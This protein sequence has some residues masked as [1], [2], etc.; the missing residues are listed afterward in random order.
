MDFG[1]G[2]FIAIAVII[3]IIGAVLGHRAEKKRIADLMHWAI[4]NGFSFD[5][6]KRHDT[7]YHASIFDRGHS[8]WSSCHAANTIPDATPGLDA[9]AS[10]ELFQ[11]H[12]AITTHNGKSSTT[13]HYHFT[14]CAADLGIDFGQLEFREEHLGDKIASTFGYDDIDFEDAEFSRRFMV[15]S[16]DRS[17]AYA[18]IGPAIM[19]T[20]LRFDDFHIETSGRL[21]FV[22]LK[23]K[24][25][26]RRYEYLRSLVL[27]I[28]AQIPRVVVNEERDLRNLPPVLEAG[29][30]A[31]QSR[32]MIDQLDAPHGV[33]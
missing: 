6:T 12:Y 19:R 16:P 18:L 17:R 14:C 11:Y 20:L 32:R 8:R 31:P 4:Q 3:V 30:A 26:S 13:H 2:L 24:P 15:K 10:L 33:R 25:D 28:A 7:S 27:S 1:L 29:D 21:F 5:P 9:P 22:H 23:G